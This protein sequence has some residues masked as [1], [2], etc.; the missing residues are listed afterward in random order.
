MEKHGTNLFGPLRTGL[1]AGNQDQPLG[2]LDPEQRDGGTGGIHL[3]SH[4]L[5]GRV[6]DFQHL[7]HQFLVSIQ[8]RR[9]LDVTDLA[10]VCGTAEFGRDSRYRLYA[11]Q[12]RGHILWNM[13]ER[14]VP[15]FRSVVLAFPDRKLD[16]FADLR[17]ESDTSGLGPAESRG[18]CKFA[19]E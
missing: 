3:S 6:H 5:C 17:L 9:Q 4:P 2:P 16:N 19:E 11:D 12:R 18:L 15:Q 13:A 7:D 8:D 14:S 10:P 1:H